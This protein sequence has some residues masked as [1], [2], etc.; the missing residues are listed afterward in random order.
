MQRVISMDSPTVQDIFTIFYLDYI[1]KYNPSP[2][3]AITANHIINCKTGAYGSNIT[4]CEEC[5]SIHYHHNSCRDRGC[6]MCQELP[7]EKWI[8]RQKEDLLDSPYFHVVFT[9]PEE[10]NALIYNNQ[11]VLYTLLYQAASE[12]IADLSA[13]SKHLGAKV[14]F[15]S[16]LHTW[17]SSMVFHPHLH[18]IVL[19]GG[20]TPDGHW[21]DKGTEFFLPIRIISK[22]FRGKY[23]SGLK[24]LQQAKQLNYYG[25]SQLYRNGY[26]FQ[27]LIDHCYNK[28]WA[29]YCKKTFG[30][31]EKVIEYL[32]RYTHRIA[33][34]NHRILS[35]NGNMVTYKA[36]DYRKGGE[37]KEITIHGV[38]FIRRFLMHVLP[39]GFI[40][41]RHYG[42]LSNRIKQKSMTHCRNLLGCKKYLSELGNLTTAEILYKLFSIDINK[43]RDCGSLKISTFQ[44]EKK[45][46]YYNTA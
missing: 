7:K 29:P 9:L 12:T 45:T 44:R 10:L 14:G 35:I 37:Y 25:E 21:K 26:E 1:E 39:K 5:G 33:I 38:E 34:S 6:P 20:L 28:E 22:V 23:L 24:E 46:H 11:K 40:R 30:N 19:G 27:S 42:L 15:L 3:Q 36:K 41:I 43:C 32:G 13:D 31:A 2:R 16:V 8:D 4:T 17:G 18:L